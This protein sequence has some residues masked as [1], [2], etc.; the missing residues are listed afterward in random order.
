MSHRKCID[1]ILHIKT[2]TRWQF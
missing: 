1:S 2:S